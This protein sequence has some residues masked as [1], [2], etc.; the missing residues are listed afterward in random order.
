MRTQIDPSVIKIQPRSKSWFIIRS[1]SKSRNS[2]PSCEPNVILNS[3][4]LDFHKSKQPSALIFETANQMFYFKEK[5]VRNLGNCEWLSGDIGS[6]FVVSPTQSQH[7]MATSHQRDYSWHRDTHS[8]SV[9]TRQSW[10]SN[11]VLTLSCSQLA[12]ATP[13]RLSSTAATSICKHRIQTFHD[14]S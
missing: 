11:S 3:P 2:I 12:P 8:P 5:N 9:I 4:T 1:D 14:R 13:H 10:K 7:M 6:L